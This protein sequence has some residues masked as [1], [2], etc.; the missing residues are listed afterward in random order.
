M[1]MSFYLSTGTARFIIGYVRYHVCQLSSKL[2]CKIKEGVG[3]IK[4]NSGGIKS[5]K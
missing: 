3:Q 4:Q 1:L 2:D 5:T